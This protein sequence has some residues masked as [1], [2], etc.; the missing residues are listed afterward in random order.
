MQKGLPLARRSAARI[1][2]TI[3]NYFK[4]KRKS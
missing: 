4:S 1:T 2:P 3:V